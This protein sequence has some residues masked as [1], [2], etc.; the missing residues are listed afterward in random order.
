M[1]ASSR[2]SGAD[3][4]LSIGQRPDTYPSPLLAAV[5]E[6]LG[7]KLRGKLLSPSDAL[8]LFS[9]M[10]K[11][12]LRITSKSVDL[13]LSQAF[14]AKIAMLVEDGLFP[15]FPV[16]QEAINREV[17]LLVSSMG[18]LRNPLTAPFQDTS[19]AVRVFLERVEQLPERTGPFL[20]RLVCHADPFPLAES[21]TACQVAAYELVDWVR[22]IGPSLHVSELR[23][24]IAAIER[25][26]KPALGELFQYLDPQSVSLWDGADL[27]S[28][29]VA[30][31]FVT[32]SL[33]SCH[34]S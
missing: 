1:Y 17:A 16:M 13:A 26:H 12:L 27:L 10:R 15:E 19:P 2:L 5:V 25:F 22:L 33:A 9:F 4:S 20:G 8:A 24:L 3:V 23:R 21:E 31:T 7:A 34:S 6:Q 11:L 30:H 18:Q 29:R 14:V 32:F 28:N